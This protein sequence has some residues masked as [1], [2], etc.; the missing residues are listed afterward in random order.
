MNKIILVGRLVADPDLKFAAGS[1][2]GIAKF[3]IAVN[4]FKKEDGADFI[5]CIAFGKTG[6]TISQYFTKG[7]QIAVVGRLKLGNYDDKDGVKKYTTDV[8]IESFD[9]IGQAEKGESKPSK[10]NEEIEPV[11][12]GDMPF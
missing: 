9:F 10:G 3:K 1:G 6:E 4:R 12:D 11:D 8:I 7:K 5:N 2:T